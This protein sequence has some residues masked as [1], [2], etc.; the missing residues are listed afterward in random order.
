MRTRVVLVGLVTSTLALLASVTIAQTQTVSIPRTSVTMTVP[1]GFRVAREFTGLEDAAGTSISIAEMPAAGYAQ[2]AATFSSPKTAS[3]GFAA[4]GVKITRIDQVEVGDR[5]IPLAIGDQAQNN[6]QFRKYITVMGGGDANAVLITFTI[7][8]S[9]S[10]SQSDVETA[11]KSTR[12]AP[13]VTLE[14]KLSELRFKFEAA[15]PFRTTEVAGNTALLASYAGPDPSGKKPMMMING[16]ATNAA[17]QDAPQEAERIFRRMAGF[18]EAQLTE[19]RPVTFAGGQGY[20]IAGD[21]NGLTMLQFVRVL[22]N[23]TYVRAVAR[24]ETSAIAEVRAAVT[25]TA[26]S[27]DVPY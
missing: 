22:P 27:V 15:A 18:A 10:F 3:S 11:L 21:A 20:F 4:Q 12:I 26:D 2:L 14:Q 17:P 7:P 16:A 6:K 13:A 23:G 24:G 9:S 1:Q 19:Q 5:T 8:S 25:A